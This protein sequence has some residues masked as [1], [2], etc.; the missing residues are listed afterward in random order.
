MARKTK[1]IRASST[2]K[3]HQGTLYQAFWSTQR[4]SMIAAAATEFLSL[5]AK[6]RVGALLKK[7][8]P[9][10]TLA[11]IAPWA[12][13]VKRPSST[14]HDP[15]TKKFIAD[16]RNATN[17][18]WHY[19][20]IPLGCSGYDPT[21]CQ[22]FI[23]DDDVV[24]ILALAVEVLQNKSQRFSPINALRLVTHLVGD[25]HQPLHVGCSF[26]RKKDSKAD[27]IT[28]PQKII[29]EGLPS[30]R[31]GNLLLLPVGGIALHSYWDSQ[32]GG[33]Q[34]MSVAQA[35]PV[36]RDVMNLVRRVKRLRA[37]AKANGAL[38]AIVA[39]ISIEIAAWATQSLLAAR[40]AYD[41]ITVDKASGA[42]YLVKWPGK[43][44]YD[45][46]CGPIVKN[47]MTTAAHSLANL[48][49][50]IFS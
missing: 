44:A 22:H 45:K 3:L 50:S 2:R 18:R 48:L 33:A 17:S 6:Q 40:I 4:H 23:R 42:K 32:L 28:D 10:V 37:G 38:S 36:P 15:E 24:H 27:L 13:N 25:I 8:G 35:V 29:A 26:M 12:D 1:L 34:P 41:G 14:P 39:N 5:H 43:T 31:G 30:D 46:R 7:L 9:S 20:D 11:D 16:P 49:N 47:R 21:H 19:A